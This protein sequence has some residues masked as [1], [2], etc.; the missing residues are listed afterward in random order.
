MSKLD[1]KYWAL[2]KCE[3]LGADQVPARLAQA[4]YARGAVQHTHSD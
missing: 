2:I 3:V 4:S 1:L